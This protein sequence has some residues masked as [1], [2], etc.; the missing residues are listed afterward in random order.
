[1]GFDE[2]AARM[3]KVREQKTQPEVPQTFDFDESYRLRGKMLGVLIR[4]ARVNAARTV[5]ECA[6]L[7]QL[8][9][10]V[11]ESWEYGDDVPALPQLELLAFFLNVPISHFWG[12]QALAAEEHDP[13]SI[14]NEYVALRQRMVGALLRSGR[15]ALELSVADISEASGL[16]AQLIEQYELGEVPIPMNHLQELAF[17]L[18]KGMDY[19]LE[20]SSTIGE[21]LRIREEWKQFSAMDEELRKFASNPLNL[22]FLRIALMFSKMPT[23][24][25]RKVA[26]GMLEITM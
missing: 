7:L 16:S 22:G 13:L 26:E 20:S 5:D 10:D 23:E 12:Q 14:Q 21:L 8:A 6:H 25:L 15:E 4:D 1:M 18:R 3:K 19:F 11:V 17:I 24:E 9:P 2:I